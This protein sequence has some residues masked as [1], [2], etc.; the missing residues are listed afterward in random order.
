MAYAYEN[1][2]GDISLFD[3]SQVRRSLE[4]NILLEKMYTFFQQ[5]IPGCHVITQPGDIVA[6]ETNKWGLAPMH[7]REQDYVRI[8]EK[9]RLHTNE[10]ETQIFG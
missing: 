4:I 10:S 5:S 9:I 1:V 2:D 7:Y 3:I 6:C 8:L